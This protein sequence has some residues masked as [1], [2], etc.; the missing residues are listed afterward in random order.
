MR[1]KMLC[2]AVLAALML[3]AGCA[4]FSVEDKLTAPALSADQ[5]AV[6]AALGSLGQ[7]ITL[8]YPASGDRRT[9]VQFL[10]L[11]GDAD[12]EAVVFY[13]DTERETVAHIAILERDPQGEWQII[14]TADGAGEEI[15]SVSVLRVRTVGLRAVLVEWKSAGQSE[16][17]LTVY[18][19]DGAALT[20]SFSDKCQQSLVYD[21]DGDGYMEICYLYRSGISEP[22]NLCCVQLTETAYAL[23]GRV[24]L[25]GDAMDCLSFIA[26]RISSGSYAAVIDEDLGN[27]YMQTEI[28]VVRDGQLQPMTLADGTSIEE[29]TLRPSSA[30]VCR[31]L[32]QDS[33]I[34][35]PTVR[36]PQTEVLQ[37]DAWIYWYL[38]GP[39]A[40]HYSRATYIEIGYKLA[41]SVPDAW[42]GHVLIYRSDSEP[43]LIEV[44][45]QTSGE[46]LLRLKILTAGEDAR[47]YGGDGYSQIAQS[48]VYRYYLQTACSEEERDAIIKNFIVLG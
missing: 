10:D 5:S 6:E 7:K 21:I 15:E 3:C 44:Q 37:P 22:Y 20:D 26:G 24:E 36:E 40:A 35:L 13:L 18:R 46:V 39:D 32:Y 42:L 16:N 2:A 47:P 25:S 48:G 12:N 41:L 23:L 9:P 19:Y 17:T 29:L 27:G 45:D 14:S 43:R 4:D 31:E 8:I 34:Y 38:L 1:K 28:F 11:D 33:F 30:P